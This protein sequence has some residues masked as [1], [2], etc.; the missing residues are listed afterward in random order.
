MIK[1]FIFF[2]FLLHN[3]HTQAIASHVVMV[4]VEDS[5]EKKYGPFP[6]DRS[7]YKQAMKKI[8][9][10]KAQ[11]VVIKF[12]LDS[13]KGKRDLAFAD[14]MSKIPTFLQF[15]L[16]DSEPKAHS[17]PKIF[18]RTDIRGNQQ[19]LL[20]ASSGWNPLPIFSKNAQGLG[21]VENFKDAQ[22]LT[23]A[24]IQYQNQL[25]PSL[26]VQI[27]EFLAKKKARIE[28]GKE[29]EINQKTISLNHRAEFS[30]SPPTKDLIPAYPLEDLLDGKI[31]REK[32]EGQLVVLGY[33]GSKIHK[34]ST[35]MGK[36]G[37]HKMFTYVLTD[38][39]GKLNLI[40][41]K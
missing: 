5:T 32:I 8:T 12:F 20:T 18:F 28:I 35:P 19:A 41:A 29:L 15:K 17:I 31:P 3:F 38:F 26:F 39:L 23:P 1:Y 22:N 13:S 10:L 37:A 40:K 2:S 34:F 21:S 30:Y 11:A 9:E 14:S 33:N 7:Y 4:L 24:V 6:I 36:L 16:D 25:I 27:A